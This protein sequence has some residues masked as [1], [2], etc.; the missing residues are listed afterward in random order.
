[1]GHGVKDFVIA[2]PIV[3]KDYPEVS[4]KDKPHLCKR[5]LKG[6]CWGGRF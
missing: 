4:E 5:A 3:V 1:M 6:D 2:V